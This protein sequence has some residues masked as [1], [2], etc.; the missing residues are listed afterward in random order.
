MD[1]SLAYE[2]AKTSFSISLASLK[3]TVFPILFTKHDNINIADPSSMQDACH[4]W[5]S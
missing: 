5:T 4:I 2:K 3:Y 1:M